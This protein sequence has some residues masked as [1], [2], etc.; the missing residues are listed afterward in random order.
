MAF[1][2]AFVLNKTS[3]KNVIQ[4][5]D[6]STGSDPNLVG[7]RITITDST[8]T[9]LINS[10]LWPIA[11]DTITLAF[12]NTDKAIN[13]AVLWQTGDLLPPP[14]T[15]TA[16]QIYALVAY[17]RDFLYSLTQL[18]ASNP[19]ILQDQ[20]FYENKNK[21]ITEIISAEDAIAVGESIANS[22]FCID[23]YLY[24]ISRPNIFY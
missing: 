20:N 7:R 16:D 5:E 12:L 2:G 9:V 21:L 18:Q 13:V 1:N 14:S 22:Q 17:G 23:R 3:N 6:S 11:D 15:Y 4:L 24:L 19:N 10:L 8:G